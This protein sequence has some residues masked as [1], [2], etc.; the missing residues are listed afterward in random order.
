MLFIHPGH[1]IFY[2]LFVKTLVDF[3]FSLYVFWSPGP[4]AQN[5]TCLKLYRLNVC[6]DPTVCM[7]VAA[8]VLVQQISWVVLNRQLLYK[9]SVK[10]HFL[11][12]HL[13]YDII[14]HQSLKVV[15]CKKDRCGSWVIPII[16]YTLGSHFTVNCSCLLQIIVQK[17]TYYYSIILV[18]NM[19]KY[20]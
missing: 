19:S 4:E 11:Q 16:L 14:S 7:Q 5:V 3:G 13:Q 15:V 9:P 2:S 17:S 10:P 8:S 18:R 1:N 6:F 12:M 20:Q